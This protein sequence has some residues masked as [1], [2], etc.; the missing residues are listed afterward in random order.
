MFYGTTI[1]TETILSFD[2]MITKGQQTSIRG[3][4][5]ASK[6]YLKVHKDT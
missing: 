6:C 1:A 3:I 5:Q 4:L 2:A